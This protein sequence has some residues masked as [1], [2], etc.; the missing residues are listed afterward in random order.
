MHSNS[1]RFRCLLKK[2]A[3]RFFTNLAS[4]LLRPETSG[5]TKSLLETRSPIARFLATG[6]AG[7]AERL[8]PVGTIESEL[9]VTFA[10][11]A[12]M[13]D[14]VDGRVTSAKSKTSWVGKQMGSGSGVLSGEGWSERGGEGGRE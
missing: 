3:A 13:E 11:W 14:G 12:A 8:L 1:S 4:R 2:A 6:G 5:G 7:L 9:E 10:L